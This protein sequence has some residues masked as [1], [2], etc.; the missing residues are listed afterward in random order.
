M[1]RSEEWEGGR[2]VE[3]EGERGQ[4]NKCVDA[5]GR[6]DRFELEKVWM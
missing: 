2:V 6:A 3:V 4:G 5:R 1:G